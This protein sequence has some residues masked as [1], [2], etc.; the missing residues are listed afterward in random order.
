LARSEVAKVQSFLMGDIVLLFLIPFVSSVGSNCFV[1]FSYGSG[2]IAQ[3]LRLQYKFIWYYFFAACQN[4]LK[5]IVVLFIFANQFP[6][7]VNC[8]DFTLIF[9]NK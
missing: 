4:S 1:L 7:E 2:I 8:T 3:C 9:F 6:K 5:A